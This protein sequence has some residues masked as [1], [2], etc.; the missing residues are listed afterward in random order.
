MDKKTKQAAGALLLGFAFMSG[1][2]LVGEELFQ[3]NFLYII[4]AAFIA[5]GALS[6]MGQTKKR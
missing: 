2:A 5:G 1:L 3:E 4:F 6:V